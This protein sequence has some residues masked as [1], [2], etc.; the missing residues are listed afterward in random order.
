M[1]IFI[2]VLIAKS[3]RILFELKLIVFQ[4]LIKI[5]V[6]VKGAQSKSYTVQISSVWGGH[7][8]RFS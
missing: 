8:D 4:V 7:F 5:Q 6:P 2:I 1:L 3:N